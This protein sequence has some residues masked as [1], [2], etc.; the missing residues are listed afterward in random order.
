MDPAAPGR[1]DRLQSSFKIS[2]Q[3]LLTAC[4]REVVNE[5]FSS[6]TDAEKARLHLMV[7]LVLKNMHVN[8]MD[9]FNDFCEETQVAAA[10]DKI[11][12]FVEE[13]NLDALASEKTTVE[14]IQ[15]KVS[16]AKKDEVEHLTGLLKK[17]EKSKNAM[18]ARIELLKKGEDST[19][20][21]DVL[22]KLTRWNS[23]LVLCHD[24][25]L[26]LCAP[27]QQ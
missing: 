5:A 22:N 24:E 25:P 21:T 11:D 1:F 15:E 20:A 4:S 8:I 7:T 23:A 19:A 6:F 14:E 12:D 9:E 2:V 16:R 13:Q 27:E 18:K 3:C 26:T 10:L 17:V